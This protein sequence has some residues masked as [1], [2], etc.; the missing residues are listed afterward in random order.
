MSE[1]DALCHSASFGV[2]SHRALSSAIACL[3]PFPLL[4]RSFSAQD[5]PES[6]SFVVFV[7]SQVSFLILV[8]NDPKARVISRSTILIAQYT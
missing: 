7:I 5:S 4:F 1:K 6:R 8:P 3:G 2:Q